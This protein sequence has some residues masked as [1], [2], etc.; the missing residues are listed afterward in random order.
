MD[1]SEQ[2]LRLAFLRSQGLC[3]CTVE[4]HQHGHFTCQSRLEWG[5]RGDNGEG[6]W[7]AKAVNPDELGGA[8]NPDNCLILCWDCYR[9]A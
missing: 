3:E 4:D 5:K 2:T 8:G 6:G 9:R 1:F 7:T